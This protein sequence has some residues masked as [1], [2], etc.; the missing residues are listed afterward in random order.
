M[1]QVQNM[2]EYHDVAAQSLR[3]II[4]FL[5][6]NQETE[7]KKLIIFNIRQAYIIWRMDN[8]EERRSL[9]IILAEANTKLKKDE[10][11]LTLHDILHKELDSMKLSEQTADRLLTSMF[12]YQSLIGIKPVQIIQRRARTFEMQRGEILGTY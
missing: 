11:L 7:A 12:V 4:S 5:G 1:E 9:E 3:N 2:M 8:P 10:P 6:Q